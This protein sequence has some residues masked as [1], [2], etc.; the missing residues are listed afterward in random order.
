LDAVPQLKVRVAVLVLKLDLVILAVVVIA[1]GRSR[2][3]SRDAVFG[4]I[5]QSVGKRR[6]SGI[7][8][9]SRSSEP[10]F[11]TSS[12]VAR[13]TFWRRLSRS[14]PFESEHWPAGSTR[15]DR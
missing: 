13:A 15:E 12:P 3:R 1:R 9:G 8:A 11:A 6:G 7:D 4:N 2:W 14:W 10:S 5:E